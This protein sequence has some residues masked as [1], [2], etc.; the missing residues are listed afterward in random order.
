MNGKLH[1]GVMVLVCLVPVL[2]ILALPAL[3]VNVGGG[4]WF[5]LILLCPLA[6]LLMMRQMHGAGETRAHGRDQHFG[7]SRDEIKAVTGSDERAGSDGGKSLLPVPAPNK[8][9]V[10]VSKRRPDRPSVG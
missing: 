8:L 2:A 9:P 1:V 7:Q 10:L 3:G 5:L 4:A 6:H